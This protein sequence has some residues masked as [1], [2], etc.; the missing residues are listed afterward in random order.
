MSPSKRLTVSKGCLTEI[1][2]KKMFVRNSGK[3]LEGPFPNSGSFIVVVNVYMPGDG[4]DGL[5][6]GVVR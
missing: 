5:T 6:D 2:V 4:T 3:N 1:N